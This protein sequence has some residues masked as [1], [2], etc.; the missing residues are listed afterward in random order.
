MGKQVKKATQEQRQDFMHLGTPEFEEV[1]YHKGNMEYMVILNAN[2][3]NTNY[4]GKKVQTGDR[5]FLGLSETDAENLCEQLIGAV[6]DRLKQ[7]LQRYNEQKKAYWLS[8][9]DEQ[10]NNW[11]ESNW[12]SFKD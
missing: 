10:E 1:F 6:S 2:A 11:D 7:K 12:N 9:F 4:L 3:S 8:E 5:L